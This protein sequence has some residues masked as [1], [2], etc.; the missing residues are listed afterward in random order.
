MLKSNSKRKGNRTR[1]VTVMDLFLILFDL[2]NEKVCR[3]T[4]GV[5]GEG[6]S[7][8]RGRV[9]AIFRMS[10]TSKIPDSSS[11][12]KLIS[13]YTFSNLSFCFPLQPPQTTMNKRCCR[14]AGSLGDS[15]QAGRDRKAFIE[16]S[17]TA[18][19]ERGRPRVD[20]WTFIKKKWGQL[21][22]EVDGM[23][24]QQTT[25]W[26][27]KTLE[28]NGINNQPQLVTL[29]EDQ[30]LEYNITDLEVC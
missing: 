20:P 14:P 11:T 18:A 28:N 16:T 2:N 9:S 25:V 21:D 7:G 30:R 3:R 24:H 29:P 23:N 26:I 1:K 10:Q 12:S 6:T 8:G 17:L 19:F 27:Y 4:R 13:V 22:L 15:P 5:P